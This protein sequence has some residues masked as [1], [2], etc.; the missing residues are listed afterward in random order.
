[1]PLLVKHGSPSCKY[2]TTPPGI[3]EHMDSVLL[4]YAWLPEYMVRAIKVIESHLVWP[5]T[6]LVQVVK[7]ATDEVPGLWEEAS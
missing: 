7:Q 6:Q 5:Y 4:N 1:M 2:S 3:L